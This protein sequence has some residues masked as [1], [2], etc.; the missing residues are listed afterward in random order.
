MKLI[1]FAGGVG[2]RLWPLS[3]V[4]SPKQFDCIFGGRSTLQLA[5]ARIAPVFGASNVFVQTI[6]PYREIIK[7]QLP[8]LPAENILLEPARRDLGPAVCFA[9][10]ELWRRGERGAMAIL[11]SDHLMEKTDEFTGALQAAERLI[12][13]DPDRFVLL[14]E[15]PRFANNNL[16]WIKLGEEIS[17]EKNFATHYFAGWKY[18]PPHEECLEMYDSGNYFWNPGYF[19][20][21]IEFLRESYARLAPE[22]Y[23]SVCAGDY[24]SAP[25]L[26]FDQAI[27]ERLDLSRAVVI[28]LEMGWSDPGTLYALKEAL[29]KS[30]EDNVAAGHVI[31]YQTSD[32]LLYNLEP[33]KILA[34]VGLN[35]MVVV[36]TNDALLVAPKSEIVHITKLLKKMEEKNLQE[37]L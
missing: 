7:K 26:H 16:G 24:Q 10:N 11:W 28:K 20:T 9:V 27:I 18:R 25:K 31:A 2:T 33:G 23:D 22:I 15:K 14:A 36:N 12:E 19:V 21:S 35:G 8:E 32:S 13:R 30:R 4:N 3:R 37:Y 34:A 1:I 17:R 29:E 5:F 6:Y